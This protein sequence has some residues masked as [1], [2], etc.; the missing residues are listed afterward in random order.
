MERIKHERCPYIDVGQASSAW[1]P[2]T[3]S[4]VAR[5]L[6]I[7][8]TPAGGRPAYNYAGNVTHAAHYPVPVRW[9]RRYVITRALRFKITMMA[10]STKAPA[11][12]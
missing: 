11:H 10:K 3:M 4:R 6:G 2:A 7:P 12:A 1:R 9:L 8:A 5:Y